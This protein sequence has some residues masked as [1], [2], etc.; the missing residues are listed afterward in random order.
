MRGGADPHRG[1][2][3][4]VP[5]G[6]TTPPQRPGGTT[7][8]E[9]AGAAAPIDIPPA[10]TDI[11]PEERTY[12]F[13]FR[14]ATYEQLVEGFARQTGLGVIG[15]APKD[16]KVNFV[17]TERLTF[18][19][20]LARV[21]MLLFNYKPNEPYWIER[22]D[23][24]LVVTRVNDIVRR[25]R[26]DRMFRSVEDFRAAKLSDDELLTLWQEWLAS[27]PAPRAAD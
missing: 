12:G 1:S 9:P 26:L 6:R 14:N 11:P 10:E 2:E 20:A 19:Q 5:R 3:P 27:H 18:E 15:E 8:E 17:T 24:H 7:S 16:G 4:R 21:Q 13:S 23:T 22:H 25:L